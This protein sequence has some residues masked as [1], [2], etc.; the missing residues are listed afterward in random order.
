MGEI[1]ARLSDHVII[2]NDNPR[3]EDPLAIISNIVAGIPDSGRNSV[4]IEPDRAK[5]IEIG[6]S[7]TEAGDVLLVAG[8]GHEQYQ[9]VGKEHLFFDDREQV[10]KANAAL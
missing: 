2:T 1:A 6:M 3:S 4:E 8:K 10:L 9:I 7:L 5:A